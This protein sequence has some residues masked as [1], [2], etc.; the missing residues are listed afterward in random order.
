MTKAAKTVFYFGLYMILEG[1]ILLIVP[2]ILL[3]L[4]GLPQTQEVWIRIV[5]MALIVLGYYYIKSAL[6]N[7]EDFFYWTIPTRIMQFIVL[8]TFVFLGL[9]GPVILLFGAIELIS[10]LWTWRSLVMQKKSK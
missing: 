1:S 7:F 4:V 8:T 3:S 6:K 9:V 10:G 5:G 2:N